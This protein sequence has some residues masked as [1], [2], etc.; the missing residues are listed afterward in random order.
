MADVIAELILD[1]TVE[2]ISVA[3]TYLMVESIISEFR[4]KANYKL[5]ILKQK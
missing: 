3:I 1:I 2:L 5:K 4:R